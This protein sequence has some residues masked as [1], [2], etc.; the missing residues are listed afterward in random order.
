MSSSRKFA[1]SPRGPAWRVIPFEA[2][3]G[4][5]LTVHSKLQVVDPEE[6]PATVTKEKPTG[7]KTKFYCIKFF[8]AGDQ[9]V[10]L[11]S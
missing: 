3:P 7:K 8:P 10:A 11:S 6:V 9:Y 2:L 5:S 1:A 4:L